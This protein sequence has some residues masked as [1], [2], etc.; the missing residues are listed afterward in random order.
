M[1]KR[2][3]DE[4]TAELDD[5]YMVLVARS[6]VGSAQDAERQARGL[7]DQMAGMR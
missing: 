7:V 1:L 4:M 6:V 2:V 5:R 3:A